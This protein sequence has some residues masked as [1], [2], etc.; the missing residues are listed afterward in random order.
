MSSICM[1]KSSRQR[2]RAA[3]VP[4][5]G[6]AVGVLCLTGLTGVSAAQTAPPPAGI[7]LGWGADNAGQVGGVSNAPIRTRVPAGTPIT[8]VAAGF[9]HSLALTADGRVLAWGD[10]HTDQYG[11]GVGDTPGSGSTP[12]PVDLPAGTDVTAITAG[13]WDGMALT[14]DGRVFIWGDYDTGQPPDPRSG[15]S[16]NPTPAPVALPAG[17][18][19]TAIAAGGAHS[20]ALTS[21]GH[22]LAWGYNNTGALG[23]GTTTARSV[24]VPVDLPAETKVTAIAAGYGYSLAVTSTGG[25]LS[26]GYHVNANPGFG[27]TSYSLVPTAVPLPA[28][29]TVTAVSAGQDHALALTSTGGVLAWGNGASG[30]LGNGGTTGTA[31]PAPVNLPAGV[32]VT[33][34]SAGPLFSL[35]LTSDGRILS[36]GQ[37]DFGQLG[38]GSCPVSSGPTPA[39]VKLPRDLRATAIAAGDVHV[40]AVAIRHRQ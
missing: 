6:A 25:L 11:N 2:L 15:I 21:D 39:W 3:A 18:D 27:G 19:V 26:W 24:P 32:K 17:T 7:V 38:H 20:L 16:E 30:A 23:D 14:S 37:N 8:A 4:V 28:G 12:V 10:N 40:L 13:A 35:A 34:I 22:V 36:W 5:A 1:R 33:A 29:V 31:T 9:S